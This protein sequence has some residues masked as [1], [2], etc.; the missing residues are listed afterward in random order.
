MHELPRNIIGYRECFSCEKKAVWIA[1]FSNLSLAVFKACIGVL[2]GSKAVLGDALYSF[3]DFLTSLVVLVGV[4]VSAKPADREHPY[5]HGKVEFLA[6]F[7]ISLLIIIG[8]IFL[9][10][11]SVKDLYL[12]YHSNIRAPRFI[13]FWA[14]VISIVANYKLSNYLFCVSDRTGSPAL[15][16][17]AKHN[18]SDALSSVLVAGAIF[19]TRFGLVILDPI[20]AVIETIDLIR[21]SVNMLNDSVRGMMDAS[22]SRP[23]IKEIESVVGFVPGVKRIPMV[24]GRR[25]GQDMLINIVIKVEQGLNLE[26]GHKISRQ[27]EKTVLSKFKNIAGVNL[28]VEPYVP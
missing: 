22:V 9:F 13:A 25:M 7:L 16:A 12:A 23:L 11:H 8:T 18:H 20:V 1:V 21:L 28:V 6:V 5:G 15:R 4:R 2:S 19:G 10:I 24:V 3:K 26:E 17:S 14:A 27:V